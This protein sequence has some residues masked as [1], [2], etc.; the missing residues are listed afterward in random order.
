MIIGTPDTITLEY[1]RESLG[2]ESGYSV[3]TLLD[4]VPGS[5][6]KYVR[7]LILCPSSSIGE[8]F[9]RVMGRFAAQSLVLAPWWL[10][11]GA[12]NRSRLSSLD[13]FG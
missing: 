8:P 7:D 12:R 9:T 4:G 2:G 3:R 11:A 10:M 5:A 1:G 6:F 13:A